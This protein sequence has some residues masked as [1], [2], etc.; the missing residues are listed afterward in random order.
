MSRLPASALGDRLDR[1]AIRA[2]A[3]A[4]LSRRRLRGRWA[5]L[6]LL[7]VRET[8]AHVALRS[9]RRRDPQTGRCRP[10]DVFWRTTRGRSESVQ[11]QSGRPRQQPERRD[12]VGSVPAGVRRSRHGPRARSALLAAIYPATWGVAQLATGALSDRIGRKWLI[13][14]GMWVQAVGIGVVAGRADVRLGF[15]DRAPCCSGI[16]TAMVY[17]TLLAAIGDVA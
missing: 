15:A 17:P 16:G 11:R 5:V 3:G 1:R 9:A 14:R 8:E 13:R 10:R 6:S 7:L 4:V 2:A 12:G